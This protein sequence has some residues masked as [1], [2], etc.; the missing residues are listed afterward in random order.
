MRILK[1]GWL[2]IVLVLLTSC[3][4]ILEERDLSEEQVQILAPTNG[5][6]ITGNS[7]SFNW[8]AVVEATAYRI[9]VAEPNFENAVQIL[10][11]STM[12]QDTTGFLGTNIR[13]I[14]IANGPYA[15]RIK[16]LNTGFETEY[17]T[18]TFI[19]DGDENADLIP[20]NTPILTI[21]ADESTTDNTN[22][23][24]TWSRTDIPGSTERDSIY[25]FTDESLE[26]LEIKGLGANKAF[27]T[28]L[29]ANTYYWFVKAFD[30]A[31]NESNASETFDFTIN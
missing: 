29:T 30:A 21:P 22:I 9:Q 13:D 1:T 7:V 3:D 24:F 19:I 20:P 14:G 4:D 5:A 16:A 26:T 6:T 8:N 23:S 25:I 28:D 12:V 15:W 17:T 31:G 27:T 11:D 18:A 2:L 10:L